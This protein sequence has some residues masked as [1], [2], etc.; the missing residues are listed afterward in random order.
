LQRKSRFFQ[1]WLSHTA[2]DYALLK[3]TRLMTENGF[4][5]QPEAEGKFLPPA[6]R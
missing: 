1:R 4:M 2:A 3:D 5:L 6:C